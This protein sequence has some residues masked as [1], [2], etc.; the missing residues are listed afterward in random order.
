[1]TGAEVVQVAQNIPQPPTAAPRPTARPAAP[2]PAQPQPQPQP[3][4][5]QPAPQPAASTRYGVSGTGVRPDTNDWISVYCILYNQG[6]NG[7]LPGTM[8][9]LKDGQVLGE[10]QF[11]QFATYYLDSGYNAGCKVEIRPPADGNYTAVLVEGGQ[12]VS[13]PINFT[14]TGPATRINFVA[15]KQK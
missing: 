13:D 6:S 3:Q 10:A 14:V 4:P 11:S 2:R 5:Q 8:R 15:W 7:L 1:V 9:V 12:V